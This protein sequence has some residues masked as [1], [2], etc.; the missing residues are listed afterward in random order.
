MK[1]Y[2]IN[3][4]EFRDSVINKIGSRAKDLL[5]E[6]YSKSMDLLMTLGK[7]QSKVVDTL[8]TLAANNNIDKMKDFLVNMCGLDATK[9]SG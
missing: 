6:Q 8:F 9:K 4:P 1:K 2:S 3:N 7:S 5:G